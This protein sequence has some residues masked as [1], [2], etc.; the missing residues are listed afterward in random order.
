MTEDEEPQCT[1]RC[2]LEDGHED[3]HLIMG[4]EFANYLYME[5]W[6]A[7]EHSL[8]HPGCCLCNDCGDKKLFCT[9]HLMKATR[10]AK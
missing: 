6:E 10:N 3:E 4:E 1:A 8:K 7:K 9:G 5:T 2:V